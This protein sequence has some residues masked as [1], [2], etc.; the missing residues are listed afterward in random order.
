MWQ[1]PG[2]LPGSIEDL[3]D[4][5]HIAA[6]GKLVGGR[7]QV[8]R[9]RWGAIEGGGW[10]WGWSLSSCRGLASDARDYDFVIRVSPP[11]ASDQRSHPRQFQRCLVPRGILLVQRQLPVWNFP[12][13]STTQPHH[14]SPEFL[15]F[16]LPLYRARWRFWP[17]RCRPSH[18]RRRRLDRTSK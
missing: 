12:P 9:A 5:E 14:Y 1:E 10:V 2:R 13:P 11:G 8:R 6:K 16:T 17:Q 4:G 15:N 18:R 3:A 7:A